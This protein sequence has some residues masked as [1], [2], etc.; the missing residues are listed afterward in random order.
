MAQPSKIL[1]IITQSEFGGAQRYIFYLATSLTEQG[2]ETIVASGGKDGLIT[3]LKQQSIETRSL[4]HLVREISPLNDL[5][6]YWEIKRLIKELR[7]DIIHLNSSKAGVLGALAAKHTGVKKIFYTVHGFVFNEPMA[8]WKKL[9]YL[10]AE[11]FTAKYKNK[12][13]CVSQFDYQAAITNRICSEDKLIVIHNGINDFHLLEQETARKKLD[14]PIDKIIIGTVANF[15]ATKGLLYL[16]QA[17]KIIIKNYPHLIFV[18]IGDGQL[19]PLL[20]KEIVDANLENNFKLLGVVDKASQYLK[21]FDLYVSPSVKEGLPFAI[22][23][24]MKAQL[25]IV[26]TNVGGVPEMIQDKKNGLLVKPAD[27][28]ALAIAINNLLTNKDLA[29]NLS[30]QAK[31][32]VDSDFSL[33]KMIDQT[34]KLYRQ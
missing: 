8:D 20:Q 14:L 23:E 6:A 7:P 32:N 13:I 30:K 31:L 26:T 24:A 17:A 22:L 19:K 25:P 18:I 12:L 21:A 27:P 15:Y 10:W 33:N 5:R 1:Y 34:E 29:L 16:I 9:I 2:Y 11:K 28:E 4:Q 3:K